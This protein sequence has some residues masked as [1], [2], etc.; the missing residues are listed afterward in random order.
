V[1][2]FV[3]MHGLGNDFVIME[4]FS[5][6]LQNYEVL[7][8]RLCDRNF[9]VGADG[10]VLLQPSQKAA[11]RM[12]IFNAD[13]SE[14]EMC[15]NA[16]R[17]IGKYLYERGVVVE[18]VFPLETF[19]NLLTLRLQVEGAK[20][21]GVEV[22]M[23]EPIL[24]SDLVP[25]SGEKRQVVSEEMQAAGKTFLF[26]AVSMGNPHCVIFCDDT[27][28]VPLT[29]WGPPIEAHPIFPRKTNVEFVEIKSPE[30]AVVRVWERG[31]GP[32]LACGTGACAVLVAGVLNGKLKRK[33]EIQLPGGV[34]MVEWRED[35][36]VYMTGPAVEVFSG[37][38]SL[39]VDSV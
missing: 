28:A 16:V 36:H 29:E 6:K 10:L 25:V 15:G 7:A 24:E 11:C 14:A 1:V 31:V 17:C 38:L 27:A 26:T 35:N 33:A 8:R 18:T 23:G 19:N 39:L 12:R 3:K 37:R 22:D 13:G 34:L 4:D 5:G 30:L 9:G 2:E 20:V 32:T 21:L